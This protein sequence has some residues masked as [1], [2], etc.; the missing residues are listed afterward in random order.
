MGIDV[1]VGRTQ[2]CISFCSYVLSRAMAQAVSRWPLTAEARVRARVNPC[3]ICGGQSG[4]GQ[5]LSEYF[6]F[7]CKY[8]STIAPYSSVTAP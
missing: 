3:G 4:T 7:P 5:V 8:H 1:E 6:G 2:I